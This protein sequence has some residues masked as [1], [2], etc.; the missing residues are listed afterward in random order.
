MTLQDDP[1]PPETEIQAEFSQT[2]RDEL[3]ALQKKV[4]EDE[5]AFQA[6]R[7]ARLSGLA[8]SG[9]GIRSATFN[10]G[11]LQGL[12]RMDLLPKFDYLST[13][14]GGGYIGGWL[15]AWIRREYQ[16]LENSPN[17]S[18]DKTCAKQVQAENPPPD[19]EKEQQHLSGAAGSTAGRIN[20]F[21][22]RLPAYSK[23]ILGQ[24]LPPKDIE[25]HVAPVSG[26]QS[27]NDG[28][29]KV[30]RSLDPCRKGSHHEANEAKPI[31]YLRQFSNY[32]T[33]RR[34]LWSA[35]TWTLAVAYVRNFALTFSVLLGA[36]I[37]LVLLVH[38]I[39]VLY[40]MLLNPS[41]IIG[42]AIFAV[43]AVAAFLTAYAIA[44]NLTTCCAFPNA[45][46]QKIE[47]PMMMTHM[48]IAAC[49]LA[50][51]CGAAGLWHIHEGFF[52]RFFSA[53]TLIAIA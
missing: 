43:F 36:L 2:L 17:S 21:L 3:E 15:T 7:R 14:S 32:L 41:A 1:Q 49:I 9:G 45:Q 53:V 52:N 10:L 37:A 50:I 4:H 6:A 24:L 48:A 46:D 47:V 27:S 19:D 5:S 42:W 8:F 23:N 38:G 13:V 26:E 34:G 51:W 12:A 20:A 33:P 25:A 39:A 40:S 44:W 16:A 30:I 22:H 11:V 35:D 18:L 29:N 31:S 28:L